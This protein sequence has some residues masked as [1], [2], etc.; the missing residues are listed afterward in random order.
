MKWAQ[1]I[2]FGSKVHTMQKIVSG[3]ALVFFATFV[4]P[5][6]FAQDVA[7]DAL[8]KSVTAEVI[9]I[10]RQDA[11]I[12]ARA[13]ANAA[14]LVDTSILQLFDFTRMIQIAVARNWRFATPAQRMALTTEFKLL[15]VRTYSASLSRYRDRIVE[16]KPLRATPGDTE[17]TV[18]S[19]VRQ[20]GLT[21]ITM[22]FDMEKVAAGWK[23]YDIKIDGIS[24]ISAYRETFAGKVR[25][26]GLDGLIQSIADQN[27]QSEMQFRSL[28]QENFYF[29][30]FVQGILQGGR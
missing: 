27:Q 29:P 18:K 23:V 2:T 28:Q 25:N 3:V 10:I 24:L 5:Y 11:D 17:V 7:A 6:S 14:A 13:P 15:L 4:T 8:L 9:A 1:M 16:F 19:V 20:S 26:G 12:Q 22:N 21:P 30:I